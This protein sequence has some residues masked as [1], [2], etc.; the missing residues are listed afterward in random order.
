MPERSAVVVPGCLAVW[1]G[2]ACHVRVLV[3]LELQMASSRT[4]PPVL[5]EVWCF[6]HAWQVLMPPA[7]LWNEDVVVMATFSREINTAPSLGACV[8][9][10]FQEGA[11]FTW[12]L[13]GGWA[14]VLGWEWRCPGWMR[15]V[16]VS[17]SPLRWRAPC[18][19]N[20]PLPAKG[21][22]ERCF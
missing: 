6:I 9:A 19:G 15:P 12:V 14:D 10:R 3:Y 13:A 18:A 11:V 22:S 1:A 8:M 16:P 2:C 5:S 20:R 21:T 17:A 4:Y 7:H